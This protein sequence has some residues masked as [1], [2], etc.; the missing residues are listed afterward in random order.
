M[1]GF[2]LI[3][4]LFLEG[5]LV[6]GGGS[7]FYL[8]SGWPRPL[9]AAAAVLGA[10]CLYLALV[11]P[12]YYGLKRYPMTRPRC[13]CCGKEQAGFYVNAV[14]WPRVVFG[15]PTCKGEFALWH[16]GRAGAKE[17]WDMPVLAL[18]WPYAFGVYRRL[19]KPESRTASSGRADRD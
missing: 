17:T 2:N 12:F 7:A 1:F 3:D 10:V 18:T 16:N 19:Q 6:V 13:A 15:C 9:Q 8:A 11:Y 4:F 5:C 14:D